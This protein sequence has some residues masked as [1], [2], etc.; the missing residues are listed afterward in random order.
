MMF[1]PSII[2]VS[3]HFSRR[4]ALATGIT[5]CGTGVGMLVFS[6]FA[7]FLM[8]RYGWRGA[9]LILAGL[10]LNGIPCGMVY[11]PLSSMMASANE[12]SKLGRQTDATASTVRNP[13]LV[14][15]VG[16]SKNADKHSIGEEH[17]CKE[18]LARIAK[19]GDDGQLPVAETESFVQRTDIFYSGSVVAVNTPA[20]VGL[21]RT[22]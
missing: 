19:S 11:L 12:L 10:V 9:T 1:L 15:A 7:Q 22:L 17:A 5:V 21:K 14:E 6:P 4:R 20:E 8:D 18:L 16:R 2:M 3:F 13:S